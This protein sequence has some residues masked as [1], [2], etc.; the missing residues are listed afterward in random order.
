MSK[1]KFF[2]GQ[3]NAYSVLKHGEG[4]YFATDTKEIIQNGLVFCGEIPE[5]L[6]E[7]VQENH[8]SLLILN[9]EGEGSIKKQI[10]DSINQ[11]A[12]QIS[13]NGVV[14]TFKELIDFAANNG[15]DLSNLVLEIDDVKSNIESQNLI[16]EQIQSNLQII[17]SN[18][19][20][21]IEETKTEVSKEIDNK[22]ETAF[23]WQNV[24]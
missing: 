2:R 6:A 8:N 7:M 13:D 10:D 3:K 16:I 1:I 4:I 14:D 22:I 19:L 20:T 12:T 5:G 18:M 21:K 17:E 15:K 11:F 23:S 24:N 9:G